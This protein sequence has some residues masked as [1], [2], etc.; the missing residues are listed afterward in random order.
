[1]RPGRLSALGWLCG[2]VAL[3]LAASAEAQQTRERLLTAPTAEALSDHFPPVPLALGVSGQVTLSCDVS[4]DGNS[5]CRAT[6]ETPAD[7]GFGAAAETLA[8]DWRFSPATENGSALASTVNTTIVFANEFNEPA[9]IDPAIYVAPPHALA[10]PNEMIESLVVNACRIR[11][12]RPCTT[13]SIGTLV[14]TSGYPPEAQSAGVNGRALI[15][16]V[17]RSNGSLNCGVEAEAPTGHSFGE[18]ALEAIRRIDTGS[19]QYAPGSVFRIPVEF[20]LRDENGRVQQRR[21]FRD[22]DPGDAVRRILPERAL[23]SERD[24][25][26]VLLCTIP[27]AGK[28]DCVV[29][30]ETPANFGYGVAALRIYDDYGIDEAAAG[31]PGFAPGDR[32][33]IPVRFRLN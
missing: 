16:C 15:A 30:S 24:G 26:V 7:N 17:V 12:G 32:I 11:I 8:S 21:Y 27:P 18:A 10:P 29:E 9:P 13:E 19:T 6:E 28:L 1:M 14:Q 33:R 3:G 5:N 2:A 23:R 25:D 4:S 22:L 20:G 31:L